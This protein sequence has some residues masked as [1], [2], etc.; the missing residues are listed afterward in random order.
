MPLQNVI[1]KSLYRTALAAI[2]YIKE[3]CKCTQSPQKCENEFRRQ[4]IVFSTPRRN[5]QA[6]RRVYSKL[7]IW[8]RA[9]F[10]HS[11]HNEEAQLESSSL[12]PSPESRVGIPLSAI[13]RRGTVY[14]IKNK[15]HDLL[16]FARWSLVRLVT[17]PSLKSLE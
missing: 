11:S 1:I 8:L 4:I 12:E 15:A 17:N 14:N 9:Q 16:S 2:S 3:F 6:W 5:T 13:K 10:F 7:R